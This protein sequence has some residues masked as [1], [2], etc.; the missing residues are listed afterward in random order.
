MNSSETIDYK[1]IFTIQRQL[2]KRSI[3]D[4]LIPTF[5]EY[6]GN[7]N[8][9]GYD[10]A[11]KYCFYEVYYDKIVQRPQYKFLVYGENWLFGHYCSICNK[12]YEFEQP[13]QFWK[14]IRGSVH[15]RKIE[16]NPYPKEVELETIKTLFKK[17]YW[18][19]VYCHPKKQRLTLDSIFIRPKTL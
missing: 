11:N 5:F 9:T 10:L 4:D 14:H 6:I 16:K 12:L 8:E 2:L 18:P 13:N 1:L 15:T 3:P 19:F 7:P 17:K